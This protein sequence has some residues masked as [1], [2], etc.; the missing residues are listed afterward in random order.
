MD[1][2]P[3]TKVYQPERNR[4]RIEV[5]TEFVTETLIATNFAISIATG[6]PALILKPNWNSHFLLLLCD[7]IFFFITNVIGIVICCDQLGQSQILSVTGFMPSTTRFS[8]TKD[9]FSTSAPHLLL[10]PQPYIQSLKT[11]FLLVSV[12]Q[13]Q[14][15]SSFSCMGPRTSFLI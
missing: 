14:F 13:D 5:E 2:K 1:H 15:S 12:A 7:W 10:S 6:T 4:P 11:N 9:W 8:V 3:V